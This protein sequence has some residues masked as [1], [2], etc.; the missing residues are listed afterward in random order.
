V[1]VEATVARDEFVR[2]VKRMGCDQKIRH[3]PMA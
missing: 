1:P 3:D 2:V